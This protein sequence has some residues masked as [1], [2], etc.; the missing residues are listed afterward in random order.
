M[1][2]GVSETT[3]GGVTQYEEGWSTVTQGRHEDDMRTRPVDSCSECD[4][5]GWIDTVDEE[6]NLHFA[7][8]CLACNPT[9]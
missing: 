7:E 9:T 8:P 2:G 5:T 1:T 4:S 6:K 3:V